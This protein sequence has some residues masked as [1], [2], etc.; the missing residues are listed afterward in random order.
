MSKV[1]Q[2]SVVETSVCC[3]LNA[4]CLCGLY[5]GIRVL[6]DM[7]FAALVKSCCHLY[8]SIDAYSSVQNVY[9]IDS[10]VMMVYL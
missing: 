9:L 7:L 1:M 6:R 5:I 3:L 8:A 2:H 10:I 4:M